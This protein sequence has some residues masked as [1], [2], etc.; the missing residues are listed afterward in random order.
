MVK[1]LCL[2]QY[3]LNGD[4]SG[5]K[6]GPIVTRSYLPSKDHIILSGENIDPR[7]AKTEEVEPGFH[8][9]VFDQE[10]KDIYDQQVSQIEQDK[11]LAKDLKNK[12]SILLAQN[13][14][15]TT[16]EDLKL[17]NRKIIKGLAYLLREL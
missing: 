13:D 15:A 12:L 17:V 1:F 3:D 11:L 6:I 16:V 10:K 8:R 5:F 7:F 2:K 9:V 4:F 14:S